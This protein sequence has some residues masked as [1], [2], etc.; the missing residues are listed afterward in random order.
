MLLNGRTGREEKSPI[1]IADVI[2]IKSRSTTA[3]DFGGNRAV[4]RKDSM[5]DKHKH[6]QLICRTATSKTA[7]SKTA[8]T[9]PGINQAQSATCPAMA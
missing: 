6:V 5:L 7:T 8:A 2:R 3:V 4:E 9:C 1:H